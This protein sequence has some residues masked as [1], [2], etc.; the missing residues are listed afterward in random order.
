MCLFCFSD[1]NL[2]ETDISYIIAVLDQQRQHK[3]VQTRPSTDA[4]R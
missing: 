3:V 1:N 2:M 4:Q